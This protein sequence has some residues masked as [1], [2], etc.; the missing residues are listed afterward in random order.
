MKHKVQKTMIR[1]SLHCV[2]F[3]YHFVITLSLFLYWDIR[4]AQYI[5]ILIVIVML[6]CLLKTDN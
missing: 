3:F 1:S 2:F 4:Y 5:I 6:Y